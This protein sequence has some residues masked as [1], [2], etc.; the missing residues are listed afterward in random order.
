MNYKYCNFLHDMRQEDSSQ[1][2][3]VLIYEN[4]DIIC[5]QYCNCS[6]MLFCHIII[7]NVN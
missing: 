1:L 5:M 3:Y 7:T 2:V 6:L 4:Y